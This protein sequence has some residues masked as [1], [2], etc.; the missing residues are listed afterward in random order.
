V[1]SLKAFATNVEMRKE[2]FLSL[3]NKV[4]A[5]IMFNN[6]VYNLHPIVTNPKAHKGGPFEGK[7]IRNPLLTPWFFTSF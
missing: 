5:I 1:R 6:Y 2:K 3:F 7:G 4:E